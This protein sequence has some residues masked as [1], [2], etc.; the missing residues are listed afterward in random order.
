[1]GTNI[2]YWSKL[3]SGSKSINVFV[4]TVSLHNEDHLLKRKKGDITCHDS[5]LCK[6]KKRFSLL[7]LQEIKHVYLYRSEF[8]LFIPTDVF[9]KLAI[10]GLSGFILVFFKNNKR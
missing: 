7:T 5:H 3:L 8:I 10:P 6:Q 4:F 2:E 1:M 9:L